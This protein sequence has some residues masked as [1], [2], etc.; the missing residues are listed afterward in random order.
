M[1][2]SDV[3]MVGRPFMACTARSGSD[4]V[5]KRRL[6]RPTAP[7]QPQ[8]SLRDDMDA[9]VCEA[10]L[11]RPA[12]LRNVATRH[13]EVISRRRPLHTQGHRRTYLAS[14]SEDWVRR[15]GSAD[16]PGDAG[17]RAKSRPRS[18]PGQ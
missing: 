8:S 7:M 9:A 14:D 5:A 18:D 1:S 15:A 6:M 4:V 11:K 10:G 2:R 3:S 13:Q 12:Y 16:D 17:A